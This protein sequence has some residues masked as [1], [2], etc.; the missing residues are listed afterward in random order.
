MN[1]AA[2]CQFQRTDPERM[3]AGTRLRDSIYKIQTEVREGNLTALRQIGTFLDDTSYVLEFLGYHFYPTSARILAM[4]IIS[5]NCLFLDAEC[6]IDSTLT[7]KVFLDLLESNQVVFDELSASFLITA[8]DRRT[9]RYELKEI[10]SNELLH[11]DTVAGKTPYPDWVYSNQI[12]GLLYFHNPEALKWI[13]AIWYHHRSRFNIYYFDDDEFLSLVKKL[14]RLELGVPGENGEITHLYDGDYYGIARLNFLTYWATHWTEYTWNEKSGYFENHTNPAVSLSKEEKLFK[15]LFSESDTVAQEAFN[16]LTELDAD[17]VSNMASQFDGHSSVRPNYELPTF[18]FRFLK[19]TVVFT[20]YCRDHGINYKGSQ[21][22]Q[23]MLR[24]L[25]GERNFKGMYELEDRIIRELT[26]EDIAAVEYNGLIYGGNW[27][28]TYSIGRILD[29]FYSYNWER[30]L[31]DKHQIAIY[32]KKSMLFQRIG[33]I[34]I[35]NKYRKKFINLTPGVVSRLEGIVSEE[36]DSSIIF[37]A[38]EI[39]VNAKKPVVNMIEQPKPGKN[40]L[41]TKDLEGRYRMITASR[42]EKDDKQWGILQLFAEINYEQLG[43]AMELMLKDTILEDYKRFWILGNDFGIELEATD[44]EAVREFLKFYRANSKFKVYE[45]FLKLKYDR[46]F[47]KNDGLILGEVYDILKYDVVDAFVGGGGGR[48]DD[49]IY[50]LIKLLEIRFG[51]TL[52]YPE[53]LCESQGV[54]SCGTGERALAWMKF[55]QDKRLVAPDA[56]TVSISH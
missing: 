1:L 41:G 17:L 4:R 49:G 50:P 48:R 2:F 23:D 46:C 47:D 33:I 16:A 18:P 43:T 27:S 35:V 21:H 37:A 38:R 39:L 34:G 54:Y 55:L 12:D 13:A 26:F 53:K 40:Y 8:I 32:L 10:T 15:L 7:E 51:T 25:R 9:T 28:S 14:T 5:E 52:G 6:R 31:S 45:H 19:A 11:L 3:A 44:P 56:D 36:K 22:L 42:N 20:K 30:L 29:K 24:E